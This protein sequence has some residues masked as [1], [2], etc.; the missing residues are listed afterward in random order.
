MNYDYNIDFL[1]KWKVYKEVKEI[2]LDKKNFIMR[3]RKAIL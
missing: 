2:C 3:K 1:G